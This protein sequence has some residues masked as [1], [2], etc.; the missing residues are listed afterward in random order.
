MTTNTLL[1]TT[2]TMNAND[3]P[4]HMSV[5]RVTKSPIIGQ[6]LTTSTANGSGSNEVNPLSII[7]HVMLVAQRNE[8]NDVARSEDGRR[9][10][11]NNI[12]VLKKG[13]Q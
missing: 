9:G 2:P 6:L 7:V 5:V 3:T 4:R 11:D 8:T 1:G 12:D 13:R 10:Y